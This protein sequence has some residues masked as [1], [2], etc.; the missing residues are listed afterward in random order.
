MLTREKFEGLKHKKTPSMQ[1]VAVLLVTVEQLFK[2][3]DDQAK[4]LKTCLKSL[5]TLQKQL[6][7]YRKTTI[8]GL[9]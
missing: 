7:W 6:E 5:A 3:N 4:E 9:A 2:I 8:K 1:D